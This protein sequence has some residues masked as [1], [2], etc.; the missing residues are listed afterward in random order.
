M[1]A[2]AFIL[3][4]AVAACTSPPLKVVTLQ[5]GRSLNS[6]N[7]VAAITSRF[8]PD[9]TIY[10]AVISEGRGAGELQVR[11]LSSGRVITEETKRVRYTDR[12]ATEFH[13]DFAGGFRPGQYRVEFFLDGQQIGTRDFTVEN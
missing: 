13:I 5:V 7:S 9:D 4:V 10:A 11:W 2:L 3:V 6:D 12:A 8:K 1:R